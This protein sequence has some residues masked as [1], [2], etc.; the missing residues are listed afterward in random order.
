M[1]RLRVTLKL[2]GLLCASGLC[3]GATFTWTA[4]GGDDYWSS[5]ENWRKIGIGACSYPCTTSDDATI[6]Y[7]AAGYTV[8]LL[9]EEIDDLT[10][11]A[12]V[13]F[14]AIIPAQTLTVDSLTLSA[15][16]AAITVEISGATIS[17]PV[18]E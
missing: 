5:G 10:I 2:L 7:D 3:L 16:S 12:S 13:E 18:Q 11:L 14:S 6:P 17:V 1:E 15:S 4:G 8:D 9:T